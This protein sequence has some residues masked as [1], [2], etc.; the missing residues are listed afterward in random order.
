MSA[1]RKVAVVQSAVNS[2]QHSRCFNVTLGLRRNRAAKGSSSS[3]NNAVSRCAI[4]IH[5]NPIQLV[6]SWQ[7]SH[8]EAGVLT[9]SRLQWLDPSGWHPFS[10]CPFVLTMVTQRAG[11]VAYRRPIA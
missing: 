11:R 6:R 10:C 1:M 3:G 7:N 2:F 8:D 4:H 5:T 9:V